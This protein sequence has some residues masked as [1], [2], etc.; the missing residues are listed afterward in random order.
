M[1]LDQNSSLFKDMYGCELNNETAETALEQGYCLTEPLEA[2]IVEQLKQAEVA[3]F[4][5]TGL[6]VA[7]KLQWLHTAGNTLSVGSY[8]IF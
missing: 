3:H 8:R 7:G 2:L 4:D 5:E 6:R 1:P